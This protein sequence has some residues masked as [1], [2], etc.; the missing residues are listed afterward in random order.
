MVGPN[1]RQINKFKCCSVTSKKKKKKKKWLLRQSYLQWTWGWDF[2]SESSVIP[3]L[4]SNDG[5]NSST[6]VNFSLLV[7]SIWLASFSCFK[8]K[9]KEE[10]WRRLGQ[11]N[12]WISCL[13]YFFVH[14]SITDSSPQPL[15]NTTFLVSYTQVWDLTVHLPFL[16]LVLLSLACILKSFYSVVVWV[17]WR[18][19]VHFRK[20][21]IN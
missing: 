20:P 21:G 7:N 6:L 13:N 9:I 3:S 4:M 18:I 8:V 16:L 1:I 12:S 5:V 17:P 14:G 15:N 2:E 10:R 19:Q 11:S